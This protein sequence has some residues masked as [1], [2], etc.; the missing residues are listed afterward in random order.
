MKLNDMEEEQKVALL[1]ALFTGFAGFV[2]TDMVLKLSQAISEAGGDLANVPGLVAQAS[3]GG[4]LKGFQG[5]ASQ[6]TPWETGLEKRRRE[7]N[8]LAKAQKYN[9]V[10]DKF[11]QLAGRTNQRYIGGYDMEAEKRARAERD[12]ARREGRA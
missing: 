4:V 3:P 6:I 5:I 11:Q 9:P 2:A 8:E 10:D 1:G 12:R 7:A